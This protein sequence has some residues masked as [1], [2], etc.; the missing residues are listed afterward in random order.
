MK[1]YLCNYIC[2]IDKQEYPIYLS[3]DNNNADCLKIDYK[4]NS[5][6]HSYINCELYDKIS[7]QLIQK[8]PI[9]VSTNISNKDLL[10]GKTNIHFKSKGKQ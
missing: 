8:I 3:S 10:V 4:D 9:Q 2:S 7:N 6:N 1:E 5:Q